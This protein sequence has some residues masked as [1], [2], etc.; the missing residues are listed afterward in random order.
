V[1]GG[2]LMRE[3]GSAY[4]SVE[5]KVMAIYNYPEMGWY[6]SEDF[7][8]DSFVRQLDQSRYIDSLYD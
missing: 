4:P 2:E 7:Y 5:L 8:D 3:I 1:S 6:K